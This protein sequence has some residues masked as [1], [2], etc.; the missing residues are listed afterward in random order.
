MNPLPRFFTVIIFHDRMGIYVLEIY[1]I[2]KL[3]GGFYEHSC[4]N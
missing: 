3:I 1:N 4:R 2:D